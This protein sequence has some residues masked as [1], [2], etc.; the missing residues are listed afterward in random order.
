MEGDIADWYQFYGSDL[1][2]IFMDQGSIAC[3]PDATST[4]YADEYRALSDQIKGAHPGALTA[5][6]PGAA[7]GQ[8]FRD[9]ADVLVTF[10]GSYADYTDSG[11]SAGEAYRPLSWVP[12]A[13]ARIWHIIY[14]AS[15]TGQLRTAL[16]LSRA[17]GAGY[18]YVTPAVPPD[19]FD[20]VPP[21]GYWSE[22]RGLR[23]D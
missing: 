15:S 14:G 10:E 12:S 6:N 2:G 9:S 13:P 4:G 22:E 21:A 18:V 17:R 3:G 23:S 5:L 19:P 11:A 8:C 20:V 1:G 16:A 7:V